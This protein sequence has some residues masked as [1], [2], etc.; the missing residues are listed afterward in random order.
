MNALDIRLVE[1]PDDELEAL[2]LR[3]R[4][5][6]NG[7]EATLSEAGRKTLEA[8][9]ERLLAAEAEFDRRLV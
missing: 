4:R 9:R 2:V 1:L 8:Y 3:L 6:V 5:T 7:L